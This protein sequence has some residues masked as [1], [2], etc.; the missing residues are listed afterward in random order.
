[1]AGIAGIVR[2]DGRPVSGEI[3]DRMLVSI[4]HRG[5]DGLHA[6]VRGSVGLGHARFVLRVEERDR[7]Q[8]VWTRDG[9]C[10]IVADVRLYNRANLLAELGDRAG[11]DG[12]PTDAEILLAAYERWDVAAIE[13]IDGDF[14]F[15]LWDGRRRRLLA[16]RD[17]LGVKP[18]FYAA[19][20]DRICFGSEAGALLAVPGVRGT[21]NESAVA[22]L[23][24]SG[25]GTAG[26]ATFYEGVARLLPG[27]VLEASTDGARPRRWWHPAARDAAMPTMSDAGYAQRF[28]ELFRGAVERRLAVDDPVAAELSGGFD[29]SSVVAAAA[30]LHGH[31]AHRLPELVTISQH[32]PGLPCD[33]AAFIEAVVASSP[34][35]AIH[36]DAPLDDFT[37]GL[38][39]E[40]C[41]TDAPVA[42]IA[43]RRRA[44]GAALLAESKC[45]VLLTGLGGDELAWDGDYELDLW[46]SGQRLRALAYCLRDERVRRDG[47]Q[48]ESLARLARGVVPRALVRAV[49]RRL[50]RR[51]R[52]APDWVTDHA[53]ALDRDSAQ[54]ASTGIDW[55]SHTQA[56]QFGWLTAPGFAWLLE[57]EERLWAHLGV[58]LRHPFLDKELAQFV[59]AIPWQARY[60]Q[61]GP[62][63]TL[64][65]AGMGARL[66]D[67]VRGRRGKTLFDS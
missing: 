38:A 48:W 17:P 9:D 61:P 8:P 19:D 11:G 4:R 56:A 13:R 41:T 32:Y 26:E 65:V 67:V 10:A 46:R 31:G 34:F 54:A 3:V 63:K 1:M 53:R 50:P 66:P 28:Y 40:L 45:R 59:L 58:E 24:L 60:R 21:A 6:D 62:V 7:P 33:E 43:W 47:S 64:L 12:P 16:A 35:R 25:R 51:A 18:L 57:T 44:R 14:A 29:S 55:P 30:D 42:D 36:F 20:R 5:P 22:Q 23:L 49:G 52:P 2:W 37:A 15:A 27:H 39:A